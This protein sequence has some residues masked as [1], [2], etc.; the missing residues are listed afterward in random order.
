MPQVGASTASYVTS[1]T[2][3]AR[4]FGSVVAPC[5]VIRGTATLTMLITGEGRCDQR[6]CNPDHVDNWRGRVEVVNSNNMFTATNRFP[7]VNFSLRCVLCKHIFCNTTTSCN[8]GDRDNKFTPSRVARAVQ[9]N[10]HTTPKTIPIQNNT[11]TTTSTAQHLSLCCCRQQSLLITPPPKQP[12]SNPNTVNTLP[13]HST[14]K[15]HRTWG[16]W[17]L[18][19]MAIFLSQRCSASEEVYGAKRQLLQQ[20]CIVIAMVDL[21]RMRTRCTIGGGCEKSTTRFA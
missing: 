8:N 14:M 6:H 16:A 13:T 7:C 2:E 19:F 18:V 10:P 20:V 1:Q 12:P 21:V 3:R 5:P 9:S 11:P 17:A 15:I 4:I